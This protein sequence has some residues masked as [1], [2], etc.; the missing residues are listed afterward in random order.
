MGIFQTALILATFLCSLVAGFLFAFA[1]VV[2]PG[3]KSLNDREFIRAF[4]VMDRI[5][6]DN[7]PIFMLVWIGSILFLI[8]SVVLGFGLLDGA[9]RLLMIFAA[10][11]YLL[12]VQLPTGLIHIPLNNRLQMLDVTTMNESAQ[13]EARQNFEPRWNLCNS[14]R[15]ALASL[16]SILLII[17]LYRL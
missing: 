16:A 17:L 1:I 2:M 10:L 14:G 13:K 5:I 4:Q 8:I 11:A 6:Q 3:V 15:T 12:G 7:Q 9:E